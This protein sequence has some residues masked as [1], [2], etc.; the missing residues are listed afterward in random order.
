MKK[1]R[2]IPTLAATLLSTTVFAGGLGLGL[3]ADVNVGAGVG[4]GG[5]G[6]QS[7]I[8]QQS[9]AQINTGS[10]RSEARQ[11]SSV[12]GD[13]GIDQRAVTR[14]LPSARTDAAVDA[15]TRTTQRNANVETD[16]DRRGAGSSF[17]SSVGADVG[18]TTKRVGHGLN[19]TAITARQS[20]QLQRARAHDRLVHSGSGVSGSVQG[21]EQL[22]VEKPA[23]RLPRGSVR[24]SSEL[25]IGG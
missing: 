23:G 2:T 14:V 10:A 5:L 17:E 19:Q 15:Q 25:N 24:Q 7:G 11:A 9:D 4:L 3:G 6:V 16:L 18:H 1:L 8:N 13:I 20:A 12:Q 21:S 22:Q